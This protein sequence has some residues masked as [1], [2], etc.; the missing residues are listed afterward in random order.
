[1]FQ[2]IMKKHFYNN[3]KKTKSNAL[4]VNCRHH[5][6]LFFYIYIFSKSCM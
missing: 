5:D 3:V 2:M 1:M 4:Q 6:T